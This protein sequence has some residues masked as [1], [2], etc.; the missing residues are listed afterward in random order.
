MAGIDLR[1]RLKGTEPFYFSWASMPGV[2][3]AEALARLP[4]EGVCIDMQHGLMGFTRSE[5]VV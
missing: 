2:H 5:S 3:Y 1:Q 4:F